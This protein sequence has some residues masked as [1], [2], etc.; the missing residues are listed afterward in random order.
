MNEAAGKN[1]D[2]E[3]DMMIEKERKKHQKP[4][5]HVPASS[6]NICTCVR[7]R[8]LFDK[9]E[10][11]GEIDIV[12]ACNPKTVVHE[13]KYKVDGITK[14]VESQEFKFD[15]SYSEKEGSEAVYEF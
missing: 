2:V 4:L 10:K 9:E 6:M 7:K 1:I 12:S 8:P 13:C 11:S 14:F 3:F 15:N 5:N